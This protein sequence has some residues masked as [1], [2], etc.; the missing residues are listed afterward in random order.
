M[1]ELHEQHGR[2]QVE[3]GDREQPDSDQRSAMDRVD[4]LASKKRKYRGMRARRAM[5]H[6]TVPAIRGLPG[7]DRL[8]PN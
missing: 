6:H 2:N 7:R 3:S 8:P 5:P 1:A 4:P